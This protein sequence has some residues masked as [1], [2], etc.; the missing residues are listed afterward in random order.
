MLEP[1]DFLLRDLVQSRVP[2]FIGPT[3]V[4]FMPPNADWK[5]AVI[6]AAEERF[7]FYLYDLRENTRLR[8]NELRTTTT[9]GQTS[10]NRPSPRLDCTYLVTAWSPVA[11]S[12]LFDP[13]RE[14]HRLLY[15]ALAV[16][17]QF[18]PID[19]FD[20]YPAA[21]PSG[22]TF[23][24]FQA[25]AP[26][27]CEQPLPM[28]VSLPDAVREPAE[29][30]TTMKVDSRPAIRLTVT[31]PVV[32]QEPDAIFDD[33]LT[34]LAHYTSI[35]VAGVPETA[36]T[37]GGRVLD[38][39]NDAID[40]AWVQLVGTGPLAAIRRQAMTQADGRF[41]FSRLPTGK[42]QLRVV[43]AGVD[44]LVPA[45]DVPLA[46]GTYDVHIP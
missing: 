43:A 6:A 11:P 45:F 7:N 25:L 36:L 12:P 28:Q 5:A 41:I 10:V 39:G 38:P 32:V 34:M 4:G 26:A 35:G 2:G 31:I 33:V 46:T 40:G 30:W 27:L 9:A 23:A 42:Y 15:Q 16:L 18:R 13:A 8:T 29:F 44:K 24:A 37:I 1:L 14:E 20:V 3:Q 17:M 22:L 21:A 19:P